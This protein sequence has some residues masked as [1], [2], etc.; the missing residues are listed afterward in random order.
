MNQRKRKNPK[1]S[2]KYKRQNPRVPSWLKMATYVAIT[3]SC[4]AGTGYVLTYTQAPA[5]HLICQPATSLSQ[6]MLAGRF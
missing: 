2:K 6:S 1:V 4:S 3:T 5:E